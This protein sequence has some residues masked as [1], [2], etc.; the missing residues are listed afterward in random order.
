M[1]F[2]SASLVAGFVALMAI[3]EVAAG[4]ISM[5]LRQTANWGCDGRD[6]PAPVRERCTG[7]GSFFMNYL[8]Q[9]CCV[10]KP[11]NPAPGHGTWHDG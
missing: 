1:L 4:G 2:N 8:G 11:S 3:P 7:R 9:K 10:N 5:K 6:A